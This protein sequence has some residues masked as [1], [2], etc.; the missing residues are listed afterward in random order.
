MLCYSNVLG[1]GACANAMAV[2]KWSHRFLLL[3]VREGRSRITA[4]AWLLTSVVAFSSSRRASVLLLPLPAVLLLPLPAVLLLPLP[5][6]L[7]LPLPAVLLLSLP[8]VLLLPLPLRGDLPL[9]QH[10]LLLLPSTSPSD[11]Q[12]CGQML[13]EGRASWPRSG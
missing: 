9:L 5:A 2:D 10:Q 4:S 7:L 1:R 8:A 13:R 6:V 11:L 12:S 3:R